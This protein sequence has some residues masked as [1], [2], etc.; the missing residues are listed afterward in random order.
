MQASPD[1]VLAAALLLSESDRLLIATRLMDTVP[2]EPPGMC[3]DDPGF[4]EELE[5]RS[6]D[7]EGSIPASELWNE[8]EQ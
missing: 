6:Q 8:G 7:S 1:E 3:W 2:D 4:L 5:R